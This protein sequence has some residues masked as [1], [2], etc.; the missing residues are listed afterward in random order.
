MHSKSDNI[1]ILIANE[2]N[3][4]IE[5]LFDF[6]LQKYQKSL[7]ESMKRSKFVFDRVYL[8]NCKLHNVKSS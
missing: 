3:E 4:T 6:I 2:K 5:E 8:L 1:K 7:E